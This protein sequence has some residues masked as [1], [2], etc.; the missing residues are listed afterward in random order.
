MKKRMRKAGNRIDH[1]WKHW[2]C[3]ISSTT[4]DSDDLRMSGV[5]IRWHDSIERG[6]HNY[7]EMRRSGS[8]ERL[9]MKRSNG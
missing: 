5:E 4:F 9:P 8:V 1:R 2:D 3:V 7:G 6:S